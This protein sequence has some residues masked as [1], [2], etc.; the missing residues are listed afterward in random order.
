M[1]ATETVAVFE[2]IERRRDEYLD[3]LRDWVAIP[4][5]SSTGEGMEQATPAAVELLESVGFQARPL[6][7]SE[8][9]P[10]VFGERA[11]DRPGPTLL[12]Y[13]HYDVQP[14][15]DLA[16][17]LSPPFDPQIRDGRIYGR[18]TGDNKGQHLAQLLAV[19]AVA[20]VTG[21]VGCH[22]KVL[23][24]GE[25]EIGSPR[26]SEIVTA[27]R[28]ALSA[29][30]AIWSDGPVHESGR[31][32]LVFGVRGALAFE[33]EAVGAATELHSG[34]WG[35]VAPNAAWRLTHALASM[36]DTNGRILLDGFEEG[37]PVLGELERAALAEHDADPKAVL[38]DMGTDALDEP[39]ERSIGE[40]LAAHPTLTINGISSGHTGPGVRTVIPHRAVARCDI[41]LLP[42]QRVEQ[43]WSAV[44]R[45]LEQWPGI[46]VRKLVAAEA[47][48]TPMSSP[49]TTPIMAGMQEAQGERPVML[50]P[51]GGTLPIAP[52][53]DGLELPTFGVPCANVDENNHAPNEN[54]D[55]DRFMTGIKS[56]AAILLRLEVHHGS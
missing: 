35:G 1:S 2:H 26:L 40:R 53:T 34:N 43:V 30:L 13:G 19:E 38:A 23:L 42:G 48:G 50:P 51:Q 44:Q 6:H 24:D 27:N 10:A 29:D 11:A 21:G 12:C 22:V 45:H 28:K 36:R 32:A 52:L 46:T 31:W 4:S 3:R 17:W 49:W 20:Q 7:A 54:L 47:S 37:V 8:G 55:I 5:I 39:A 16:E 41:R 25:E 18:G 56:I 33:V 15:G 9:W 14:V